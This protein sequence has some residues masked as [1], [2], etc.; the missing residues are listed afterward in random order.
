MK[1]IKYP[2]RLTVEIDKERGKKLDLI[3]KMMPA[4]RP[5]SIL[6]A[7]DFLF[8]KLFSSSKEDLTKST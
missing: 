5:C 3:A 8:D 4:S 1:S 2:N 6:A 7:I